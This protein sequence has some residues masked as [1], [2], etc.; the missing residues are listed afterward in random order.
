METVE[1]QLGAHIV[2]P[3]RV[4]QTS[5][6]II[7]VS[8]PIFFDSSKVAKSLL[9]GLVFDSVTKNRK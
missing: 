8:D 2:S 9:K 5:K 4:E 1:Y 7:F 3:N 6:D